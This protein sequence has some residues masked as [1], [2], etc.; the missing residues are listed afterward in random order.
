MQP[1][2]SEFSYGYAIVDELVH[3]HNVGLKFA[4]VFPS[5]YQEGQRG[6]G[7]DVELY[8]KEGVPLFLQ[9]KTSHYMKGPRTL[10][11]REGTF[12]APFYR[13]FLRPY[14]HSNQHKELLDLE[15]K[16]NEVYYSA[17]SFHNMNELNSAYLQHKVKDRSLWVN[18]SVIGDLPDDGNHH[19]SFRLP[20]TIVVHSVP[21]K[22]EVRADYEN[23]EKNLNRAVKTRGKNALTRESISSLTENLK[24]KLREKANVPQDL[25]S[26]V[27]SRFMSEDPLRNLAFYSYFALN[28]Q[29]LTV[30][31][32]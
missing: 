8:R 3:W 9:F 12:D 1:D 15:R 27:E 23:F 14:R 20:S 10:E 28:A 30:T 5:L 11:F 6:M 32:V 2:F 22:L 21:K 29:L 13:M 26:A 31:K 7:Y 19:V 25:M 4:P 17:P 16:G 18:P 24:G